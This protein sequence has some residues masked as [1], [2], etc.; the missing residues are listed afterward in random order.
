[1]T[2]FIIRRLLQVIPTL[3]A[4]SVLLFIWLRR[5]PGGPDAALL[6]ERATP[7]A[8]A[9]IRER[10]GL[11]EPILVQYG[12][13]MKDLLRLDFGVS[14]QTQQPVI[15]EFLIRFPGTVELAFTALAIAVGVG[16]PVGYL[17]ARRRGG[18]LDNLVVS[19]SMVG[20]CTPVFFL[21]FVLKW[22]FGEQ[23][24]W[25]PTF[26]RQSPGINATHVT[27][28]FVL[29]G[30]L[31]REWDAAWDAFLHLL[32]PA[33]AVASIPFAVIVRMTRASVLEVLNEDY[34]RTAEAKGLTDR[35]IRGRHV[36][37]NALLPVVTAIGVL[38][39]ALLSGAVLTETVFAFNGIGRFVY[40]A[41]QNAD[42]PVLMAFIMFIALT[43]VTINLLV[44]ISYSI[45]DPRVRV[46]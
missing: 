10:L 42:Y 32:L 39:G 17:A 3:A 13:Y 31:T 20:I 43:F 15:D 18:W 22:V 27:N 35:T 2:R 29:D 45:I 19:G 11:D 16:I 28:F 38:A 23:L 12:R 7:E 26:G 14:T 33:I 4:L 5:L 44:D 6:G 30:L 40:L 1:M 46:H 36:L 34:V 8:R 37:R 41:I 21:A 9:A 24:G 25:L